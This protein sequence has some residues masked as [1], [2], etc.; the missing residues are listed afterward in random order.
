MLCPIVNDV[1]NLPGQGR[2]AGQPVEVTFTV[3][4]NGNLKGTFVDVKSGE[5]GELTKNIFK[6][7]SSVNDDM[8]LPSQTICHDNAKIS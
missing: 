3:D 7:D 4:G 5:R 8:I 1:I 6:K 2:P